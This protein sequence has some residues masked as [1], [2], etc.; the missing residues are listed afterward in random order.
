MSTL[1]RLKSEI[2]AAAQP[3]SESPDAFKA[4]RQIWALAVEECRAQQEAVT[5]EPRESLRA[6]ATENERLEG[7]AVAAQNHT[8]ELEQAAS[9]AEAELNRVRTEQGNA[10]DRSQTALVATSAQGADALQKLADVQAARCTEVAALQQDLATA[11]AKAHGL[12][13]KLVRAQALREGRGGK[14]VMA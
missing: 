13:L 9:R 8:T 14:A 3:V 5:A 7:A 12:E 4:F 2:E 1:V 10:L 6:L 11:V